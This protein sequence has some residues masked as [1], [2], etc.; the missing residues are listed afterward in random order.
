MKKDKSKLGSAIFI[1]FG[2]KLLKRIY[3]TKEIFEEENN[4][5]IDRDSYIRH[6]LTIALNKFDSEAVSQRSA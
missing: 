2:D 3:D 6:L 4:M 1:D 5:K